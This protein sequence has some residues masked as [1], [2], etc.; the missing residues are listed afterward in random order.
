V[1]NE[2]TMERIKKALLRANQERAG[3]EVG[4]VGSVAREPLPTTTDTESRD[5]TYVQTRVIEVPESVFERN[6]IVTGRAQDAA[7]MA[8]KQLRTQVL[9]RLVREDWQTVAIVSPSAG[10]GKTLTAINLAISIGSSHIHSALLVD[11]DWWA[12]SVHKYFEFHPENDLTSYLSGERPLEAV[13]VNPGLPRFCFLPQRDRATESSERLANLGSFV[14]AL[15]GR[16]KRR[17][18]LFDLPPLLGPD[19][20]LS[21]LPHVDCVLLVVQ[22]GKTKRQEIARCLEL[23][24]GYRVLGTVVNKSQQPLQSY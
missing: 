21:F 16:Y 8:Y 9:Q 1:P 2:I 11:L 23:L 15:K 17:I 7:T 14:K 13:F 5:F 18:V 3:A 12:P 6:R 22:E 19:D 20:A 10:D 4:G 24:D